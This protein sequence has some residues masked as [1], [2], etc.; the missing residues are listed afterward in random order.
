MTNVWRS[1]RDEA[2]R[3]GRPLEAARV[4]PPPAL[5]AETGGFPWAG[6]LP[7]GWGFP[8]WRGEPFGGVGA[9]HPRAE[10]R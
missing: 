7:I 9:A 10:D 4:D 1:R 3:D 6:A 2:R 5:T 8:A